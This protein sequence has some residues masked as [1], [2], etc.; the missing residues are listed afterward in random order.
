MFSTDEKIQASI[1]HLEGI[2]KAMIDG[3]VARNEA[4]MKGNLPKL[5]FSERTA[6]ELLEAVSTIKHLRQKLMYPRHPRD[7]TGWVI[8]VEFLSKIADRLNRQSHE[9]NLSDEEPTLEQIEMVL[10]VVEELS[11]IS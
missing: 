1:R 8:S 9:G 3:K 2:K 10:L 6:D 4:D 7:E 5:M 11:G